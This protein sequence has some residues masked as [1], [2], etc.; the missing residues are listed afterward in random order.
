VEEGEA[1]ERVRWKGLKMKACSKSV[2]VESKAFKEKKLS[3][4]RDLL[5]TEALKKLAVD[6][7]LTV[8]ELGYQ[9]GALAI[10]KEKLLET[11]EKADADEVEYPLSFYEI[12]GETTNER[13]L[14]HA[15]FEGKVFVS[16]NAVRSGDGGDVEQIQDV[17][18]QV[19]ERLKAYGYEDLCVHTGR[20]E[21]FVSAKRILPIFAECQGCC[22]I[23]ASKMGSRCCVLNE[24][25]AFFAQGEDGRNEEEKKEE[26]RG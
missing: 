19:N 12:G 17:V 26:G 23:K 15:V 25:E 1:L 11:L 2:L 10:E 13:E 24:G 4:M 8:D 21:N 9:E 3:E 18:R 20:A 5:R 6:K 16:K 22:F 14:A 7:G